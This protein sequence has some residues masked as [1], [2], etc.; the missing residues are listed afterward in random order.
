MM[1]KPTPMT[2]LDNFR[3]RVITAVYAIPYGKVT[4]YGEVAKQAGSAR[5]ARQVGGILKK[6]P[7][8]SKLPWFRVVNRNGK[9][10][11][12]GED[13]QRQYQALLAEGIVFD[14]NDKIDLLLF[15]WFI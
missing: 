6:L 3:Q 1:A 15:G 8:G 9:I 5:A 12:T 7:L 14:G 11:L 13:Y 10:S 2:N 4:T